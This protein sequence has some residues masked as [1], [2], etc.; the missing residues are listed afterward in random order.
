MTTLAIGD[1]CD[2]A[3]SG[4]KFLDAEE[5]GIFNG[6]SVSDFLSCAA[7]IGSLQHYK[8]LPEPAC[9]IARE[10][11]HKSGERELRR[12]L[13]IAILQAVIESIESGRLTALP[14]KILGYQLRHLGR[15]AGN[16]D[17]CDEWLDLSHD[18]F[19]KEFGLASLRLFA[20]GSQLIDVRCGIP[21]S[22]IFAEG[23]LQAPGRLLVF[24]RLGGFNPY[25]EIHTHKFNLDQFHEAG[26]EE[27]YRC[28]AELYGLFPKS[29]GMF[30]SSWF[31]DP[32]LES[33]SPRLNYLRSTPI[34]GGAKLMFYS[35]GGDAIANSLATSVS[36]RQL[37]GEKKY[38]P[39]NYLLV[40]GREAQ[41]AWAKTN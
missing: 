40:W 23:K 35:E 33:I 28:C 8:I 36:R 17:P 34:A 26:W 20:A 16:T 22:V 30:G 14:K 11:G 37:F 3:R 13:R 1:V 31:F 25:F 12:F 27:C 4:L 2:L 24:S 6:G 32:A 15:I 39:K 38:M 7:K 10:V 18:L 5:S 19:H 21:R 29:L 9:N 41:I